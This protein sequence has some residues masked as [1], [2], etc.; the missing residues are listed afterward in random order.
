[1][2]G[3]YPKHA[4][5]ASLSSPDSLVAD[6]S[7]WALIPLGVV[8]RCL[9]CGF[10]CFSPSY[11]ALWDSKTPHRPASERVSC[12]LETSSSCL[13]PQDEPPSLMLLSPSLSF[14]F[15][16]TTFQK[17][18]AAFLGAFCPQRSE[19][20]LWR[21]LSIQVIFW[22]ICGG[23][24]GLPVLI[25][26]HLGTAPFCPLFVSLHS[27]ETCCVWSLNPSFGLKLSFLHL[28][29]TLF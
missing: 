26:C 9:C 13:P 24:N 16:P 7:I 3:P 14:I 2:P 1:M 17:E 21:L 15:C 22:W 18:W 10:V 11:V 25:L 4:D 6:T 23:E 8:V 29:P 20:V 19:V 5:L 28:K 12:C 27:S